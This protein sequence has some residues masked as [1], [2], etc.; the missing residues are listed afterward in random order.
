[1][2]VYAPYLLPLNALR[3]RELRLVSRK[4]TTHTCPVCRREFEGTLVKVY[5]TATCR[6][7]AQHTRYANED[8]VVDA[9][10]SLNGRIAMAVRY[11]R[12]ALAAV[13]RAELAEWHRA[14][15]A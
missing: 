4:I 13:L 2:K 11:D 7:R 8:R 12:P 1:M 9:V 5:C 6:R 3:R 15:R 14:R 10:K